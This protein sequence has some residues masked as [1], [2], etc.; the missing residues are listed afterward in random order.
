MEQFAVSDTLAK[1]LEMSTELSAC[2]LARLASSQQAPAGTA[3]HRHFSPAGEAG[4]QSS[5]CGDAFASSQ[6]QQ[7][8]QVSPQWRQSQEAELSLAE[9]ALEA[10]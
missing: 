7:E 6:E 5:F 3:V 9:C 4:Q 8:Q 10:A 1:E 2:I